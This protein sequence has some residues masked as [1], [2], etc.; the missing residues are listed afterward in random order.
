MT[1]KTNFL[2]IAL[3]IT[4]SLFGASPKERIARRQEARFGLFIHR[5][6]Y[7]IPARGEWLMYREHIAYAEY[8]KPA[9]EFHP[10]HYNPAEWAAPAK[11]AGMK[12]IVIT[13]RHHGGF[14]LFD[15]EVSDFTAPKTSAGR[16]L[17]AEFVDACRAAGMKFGF[18][19]FVKIVGFLF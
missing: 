1:G 14:C 12:Y 17:I 6:V 18:C 7:S 4:A 15:S 5:G 2:T 9:D 13:T 19:E 10:T 8:K 16:D 11:Q 3:L